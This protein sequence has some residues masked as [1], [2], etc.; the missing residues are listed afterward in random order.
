[1]KYVLQTDSLEKRYGEYHALRGLTMNV[2][3]GS[4]YGFVGRNGAGKTTLFRQICGLQKPTAGEYR[5]FGISNNDKNI[6]KSRQRMGSVVETPSIYG[7]MTAE[8]NLKEQYRNLGLPSFA[9]I[10]EIL[11]LVGLEDTGRKKARNFSFGMRQRLGIAIALAGNPDFLV[12]DEPLNGLDPQGMIE[13]R[14][15]LLNLNRKQG[16]TILISSHLL[17]ELSKVATHFGFI[18]KGILV[19]EISAAELEHKCRKRTCITV[20]NTVVLSQILDEL[21]LEHTILSD[22]EAH[23]YGEIDITELVLR[24]AAKD[25]RVMSIE[26]QEESLENYFMNLVGG[27]L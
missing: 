24:L 14:E 20:T 5:I 2:P 8:N 16:V 23:V 15:L 25:C 19:E 17:E 6:R 21:G 12:L 22:M 26:T 1:M 18:D 9:D 7:E 13:M 10:P 4:I 27:T 3:K 11:K